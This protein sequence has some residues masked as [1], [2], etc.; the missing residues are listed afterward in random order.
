MHIIYYSP[1]PTHDIVSEVGYATHQREVINALRE[2]G[3][4]V[5]PV[6][7]GGTELSNLNPLTSGDYKPSKLKKIIKSLIP[8]V[9][10]TTI[11][12]LKLRKHDKI[13]GLKLETAIQTHKPDLLYERSEYLQDSGAICAE[14]YGLKYFLEVNAP[15]VEEMKS[16][17]GKS[18]LENKAHQIEKF[19]LEKA[20]KIIAVSSALA[21]FLKQ[22][23]QCDPGKLF[24][25]PNCINPSKV[26][27]DSN[28]IESLKHTFSLNNRY[29]FGF[30]GSIF[31]YHG[32]DMLIQAFSK[33]HD[34]INDSTLMIVGDGNI[35]DDLKKMAIDLGIESKVVFT[36]KI[37]HSKVFNY[38]SVMD[39]CIMAKSNWYGSPVKVFEYGLMKKPIIAPNTSPIRD[40][41]ENEK[42]ALIIEDNVNELS[43][44]MLKLSENRVLASSLATQFNQK[45][46]SSYNWSH[47]AQNII[48]LCE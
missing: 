16:F 15:F 30:V 45:V 19:K 37:P 6:I 7:M 43:N 14:K 48:E 34:K 26:H 22:T 29:I 5:V 46:M 38:M 13:A 2:A 44:A 41:M 12:N 17:E 40:V 35:I 21:D 4:T 36:G 27:T 39:V 18:L 8:R 9:L 24:V 11:N 1:H 33:V 32:V 25:Q 42:D 10:W 47:A 31:P 23:Y 3:H 28:E 20:H